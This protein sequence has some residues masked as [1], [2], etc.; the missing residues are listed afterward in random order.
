MDR[1]G[2]FRMLREQDWKYVFTADG[3]LLFDMKNN[4]LETDNLIA[5]PDLQ[6]RVSDMRRSLLER[7][8]VSVAPSRPDSTYT[9]GDWWINVPGNAEKVKKSL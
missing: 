5:R 8:A 3:D 2:A 9:D 1:K 4:P 6:R 7:M